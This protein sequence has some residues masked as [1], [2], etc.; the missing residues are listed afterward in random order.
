MHGRKDTE[1][2]IKENICVSFL[3]FPLS[4]SSYLSRAVQIKFLKENNGH[5]AAKE[6]I[7]FHSGQGACFTRLKAIKRKRP[8]FWCFFFFFSLLAVKRE[9]TFFFIL[10]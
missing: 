6:E 8:F 4:V 3:L 2:N 5:M 1:R 10:I 7:S 9:L